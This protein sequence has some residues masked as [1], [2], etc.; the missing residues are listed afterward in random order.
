MCVCVWE[1]V[2]MEIEQVIANC[3]HAID[4]MM[5]NGSAATFRQSSWDFAVFSI[6]PG[7]KYSKM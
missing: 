4:W 2:S 7:E 1:E 3:L 6:M 5:D